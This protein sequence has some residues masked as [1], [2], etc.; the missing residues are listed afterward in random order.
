MSAPADFAVLD[1][2][3]QSQ[4][5][6]FNDVDARMMLQSD[7]SNIERAADAKLF[8]R[9]FTK[10]I[11]NEEKS[12]EAKRAIFEE[13]VFLNIKIPGDKNNDVIKDVT[14]QPEYIQRFPQHYAQFR[15]NQEQVIG[16]PL[17]AL[18]FL[19]ETQVEE[20]RLMNIRTVEQ[21][22]GMA[23]VQAQTI[24]GSVTHKKRAQ[25]WLDSFKGVD[26]LRAEYEAAAEDTA[27][28]LAELKAQVAKLS[29]PAAPQAVKK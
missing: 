13:H 9:F 17:N 10:P 20:Y 29:A 28:Q 25:E 14:L 16:T 1:A 19:T 18:P 4:A 7:A 21:L 11:K 5:T 27:K 8:V 3:H 26:Q 6:N 2:L 24:L 23:D 22:A 12:L 15:K